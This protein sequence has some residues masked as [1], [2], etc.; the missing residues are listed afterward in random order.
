ML[1]FTK[2]RL[3]DHTT[4]EKINNTPVTAITSFAID[5]AL[6]ISVGNEQSPPTLRLWSHPN[7]VVLGIPDTRLPYIEE[8]VQY[9]AEKGY[10]IIVRNSGGL[11]VAL[12]AGVLNM[13]LILPNIRH[14]SIDTAY[15]MMY[16]FIEQMLQDYTDDIK[17]YE[18]IGSYCPGDYDLSL[19]GIKFAGISQR[20]VRDGVAVQVY[21][22]VTGNS[23]QRAEHIQKF[24]QISKKSVA[25]SFTYPDIDPNVLGSLDK[26][27]V[28]N[29]TFDNIKQRAITTLQTRV[30]HT[31][32]TPLTTEEMATF[33]KR[34]EQMLKRNE[35][36][37]TWLKE[38]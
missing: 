22:D 2:A 16:Q 34:F 12:D 21:L 14:L 24:Y 19:R 1:N 13:S 38:S 31:D 33:T 25:T 6:A 35:Q 29:I 3:I 4:I 32:D 28:P 15:E 20:R 10:D 36:I 26:L 37:Q 18:I 11:A 7:T 9:L 23:L 8:G 5:D 27:L 30:D 17:A